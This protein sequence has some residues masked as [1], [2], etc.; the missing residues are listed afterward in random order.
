MKNIQ[1]RYVPVI[2]GVVLVVGIVLYDGYLQ[3][4]E[5]F[6]S[7]EATT[8]DVGVL[9]LEDD[10]RSGSAGT[11]TVTPTVIPSGQV[12]KQSPDH[13]A[14]PAD[15]TL[16]TDFQSAVLGLTNVDRAA[17]GLPPLKEKEQ[18]DTLAQARAVGI[19]A[20]GDFS[21][22]G[23]RAYINQTSYSWIGE[24]L[25]TDFDSAKQTEDAWMASPEHRANILDKH[26][27]AIG[28]GTSCNVTVELFGGNDN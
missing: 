25:A 5:W 9:R 17:A 12:T 28:I 3:V 7:H 21:H 19:C 15:E 8:T 4:R 20:S 26:F 2:I 13:V 22:N 14:E 24:N 1:L 10:L 16:P 6:P 18:L 27:T 11:A 23:W